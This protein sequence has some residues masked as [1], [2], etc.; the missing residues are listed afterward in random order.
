MS[1]HTY[2]E[3]AIE[4]KIFLFFIIFS[5]IGHRLGYGDEPV[6]SDTPTTMKPDKHTD[7]MDDTS[8]GIYN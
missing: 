5:F 1:F 2:L 4:L 7:S 6:K 8:G 3:E